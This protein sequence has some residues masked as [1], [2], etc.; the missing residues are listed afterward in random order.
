MASNWALPT[1]INQFSETGAENSHV[2]WQNLENVK[3]FNGKS[4]KT[5]RDLIHIARDPRHD[6]LEKTYFLKCTGFNFI[7]VPPTISG[8]ELKLTSNRFGRITDD[9]I[10]LS[11]NDEIIGENLGTLDLLPNKLYGNE[12]TLWGTTLNSNDVLQ[13]SFGIVLR[14]KSHP[15]WPHKC[16]MLID[17]VELRVH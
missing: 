12:T 3:T 9:T 17:A 11:L 10:Q 14:F 6:I 16:S 8:I 5:N 1:I 13:L 2:S 15:N 4:T 7:N